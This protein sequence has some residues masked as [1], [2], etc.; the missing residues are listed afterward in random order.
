MHLILNSADKVYQYLKKNIIWGALIRLF[1]ESSLDLFISSFIRL[2]YNVGLN[3]SLLSQKTGRSPIENFDYSLSIVIL[4]VACLMISILVILILFSPATLFESPSFLERYGSLF[5][6]LKLS[7]D[8]NIRLW[9]N[10][11]LLVRRLF[12]SLIHI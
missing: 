6:G 9:Y 10:V 5:E 1:I 8:D 3:Y 7:K 2:R 12:L 4:V 11:I